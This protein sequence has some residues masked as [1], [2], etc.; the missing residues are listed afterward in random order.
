MTEHFA[1]SELQLSATGARLGLDNI[2]PP[3]LLPNMWLVAEKLEEVRAHFGKPVR[4]LSCYRSPAVNAAVGGS[5]T[6]AHRYALAADFV[7]P[8]V[9]LTDVARWCAANIE[10]FDQVIYEFGSWIHLGFASSGPRKQVLTAAKVEGKTVYR[11]GLE[12]V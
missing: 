3:A 7:I 5:K 8:G 11:A 6:S 10:D 1:A 2:C 12:V 4:V 9:P